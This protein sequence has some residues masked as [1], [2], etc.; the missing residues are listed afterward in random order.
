MIYGSEELNQTID[1]KLP[2]VQSSFHCKHIHSTH[3]HTHTERGGKI[4]PWLECFSFLRL[5]NKPGSCKS[6]QKNDALQCASLSIQL[7]T[8]HRQNG[9]D[10]N[11]VSTQHYLTW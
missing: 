3:T 7:S 10:G 5:G 2:Q 6:P 8:I 4:L 11:N 1:R 9:P